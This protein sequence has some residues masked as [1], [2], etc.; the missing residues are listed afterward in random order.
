MK[1]SSYHKKFF[2]FKVYAVIINRNQ[3]NLM[4]NNLKIAIIRVKRRKA[5]NF[6]MGG[7]YKNKSTKNLN[8]N[9]KI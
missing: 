1:K 9:P 5:L 4:N 2:Q 6:Y 8:S 3:I 7:N